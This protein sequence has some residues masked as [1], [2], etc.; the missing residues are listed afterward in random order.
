MTFGRIFLAGLALTA[1]FLGPGCGDN[2]PILS[3]E[4]DEPLYR[5]GQQMEKQGRTQEALNAYLKLIAKRGD[6]AP[7]SHL[8][9]GLI[10][11]YHIKDPI[12]AIYYFR[13]Y[14]E[15]EPNSR[16]ASEVRGLIDT[17]K[18][19]FARTL[20]ARPLDNPDPRLV[21]S[22][23]RERLRH[24]NDE[25]KA[26]LATARGGGTPPADGEVVWHGLPAPE[27]DDHGLQAHATN[28]PAAAAPADDQAAAPIT[29]APLPPDGG[30]AASA[31]S[32]V[33]PSGTTTD[34]THTVVKGDTLFNLA[35][36]YYGT[37][38][39]AKVR[40]IVAANRDQLSSESAPLRIGMALKIP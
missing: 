10:Y 12:G 9:A 40:A 1:A 2:S 33:P 13:K 32:S 30:E 7:D 18:L 26:E 34:R 11:F 36:R 27:P 21:E 24:E 28:A 37:R 6:Q 29:P 4:A 3:N 38:S 25:L 17:A 22:D 15:L 5:D 20:P 14:L 23:E 19:N 35:Q 31:S 39:K 8:D 16:Q